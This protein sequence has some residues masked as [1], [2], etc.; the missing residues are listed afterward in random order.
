MLA[1]SG[2]AGLRRGSGLA[3]P[4]RA[5]VGDGGRHEDPGAGR[6][7]GLGRRCPSLSAARESAADRFGV[8]AASASAV[9]TGIGVAD[10]ARV[11]RYPPP[12]WR[13]GRRDDR[14]A[15]CGACLDRSGELN[16][17]DG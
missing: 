12:I 10:A 16:R 14:S 17:H 9:V 4:R 3:W 6:N 8:G 11:R 13:C 15:G 1:E 7:G 2:C 5:E